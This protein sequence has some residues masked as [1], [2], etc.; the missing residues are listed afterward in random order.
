MHVTIEHANTWESQPGVR[1]LV[2]RDW[3]LIKYAGDALQVRLYT[4]EGS[5]EQGVG[6]P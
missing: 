1:T 6:S 4:C 2:L 3:D 5:G